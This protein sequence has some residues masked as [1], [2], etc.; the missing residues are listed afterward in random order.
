MQT[1]VKIDFYGAEPSQVVQRLITDHVAKLEHV[2][3]GITA[4]HVG[5]KV[6]S[7]RHRKGGPYEVSVHMAL[8]N[9]REVNVRRTPQLDERYTNVLFAVND[10]FRRARRQLQDQVRRLQAS[11]KAHEP[12]PIGTVARF[13]RRTGFGFIRSEGGDEVYFH[14]NSVVGAPL[15]KI[16]IG[17]RVTFA[18]EAGEKGPQ[19][20]T[21]RVLGKHALR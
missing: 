1:A 17:T 20:S 3:G 8:P 13:N 11:T 4:C 10:A 15:R 19:A 12:Q 21:V 6:R 7:D 18:E 2:Y 16:A 5:L 14:K 9:G